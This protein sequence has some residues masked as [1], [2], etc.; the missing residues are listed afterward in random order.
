M[1]MMTN[2]TSFI[3]STIIDG[4]ESGR[5]VNIYENGDSTAVLDGFTI[6]NGLAGNGGGIMLHN[7]SP[8]LKNLIVSNNVATDQGGGIFGDVNSSPRILNTIIKNNT[9]ELGGGGLAF[10]SD[11]KCW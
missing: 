4:N 9:A 7:T 2:D 10:S 11:C 5:V 6:T 8:T 1:M 3:N